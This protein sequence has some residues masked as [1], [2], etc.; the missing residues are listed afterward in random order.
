MPDRVTI[1]VLAAALVVTACGGASGSTAGGSL[2][3]SGSPP[4]PSTRP[5]SSA[6]LQ[7]LTPTQGEIIKGAPAAVRVRVSLTGAQIVPATTTHITPT[8]GHLHVYLDGQIVSMNF[9]TNATVGNVAA[10]THTLI[11]E[12]V[13]SDHFP[14]N[15]DVRQSVRFVVTS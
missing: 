13:A 1:A 5:S 4:N 12:F 14:F 8:Q 7:I 11:V 2:T 15:P 3:P 6:Q 9:S 10:G